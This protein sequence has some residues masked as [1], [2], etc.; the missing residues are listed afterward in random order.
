MTKPHYRITIEYGRGA[1]PRSFEYR[2]REGLEA[3]AEACEQAA[4]V[5][6]DSLSPESVT[7]TNLAK[8]AE[9]AALDRPAAETDICPDCGTPENIVEALNASLQKRL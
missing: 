9:R 8:I 3:F 2:T 5:L 7:I 6:D 4:L 1:S